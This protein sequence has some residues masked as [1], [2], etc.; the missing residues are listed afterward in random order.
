MIQVDTSYVME[1]DTIEGSTD[2][3]A[4]RKL[5]S[6]IIK[7]EKMESFRDTLNIFKAEDSVKIV[8]SDF[9]SV[10]DLTIYMRNDGEIITQKIG[11]HGNQPVLWF[12]NSQL[13][14]D[15][16]TIYLRNNEIRMLDVDQSLLYFHKMKIIAIGLIKF[17]AIGLY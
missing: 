5:D 10:N 12:G 4:V 11:A 7:S 17:Q 6:L 16:V 1:P 14:G 3:I 15:S 2:S 9:A 13:T 8:R